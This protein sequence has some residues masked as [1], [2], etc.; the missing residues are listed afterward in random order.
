MKS[1]DYPIDDGPISDEYL[2]WLREYVARNFPPVGKLTKV[3]SFFD[4]SFDSKDDNS[5]EISKTDLPPKTNT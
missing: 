1:P 4:M 3:S 2:S 5:H